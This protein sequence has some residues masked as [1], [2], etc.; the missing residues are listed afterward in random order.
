[1]SV[2][3]ITALAFA[4]TLPSAAPAAAQT[5]AQRPAAQAQ[6]APNRAAVVR[7]L[8]TAYAAVDTNKDGNLSAAELAAAEGKVQQ[9]RIAGLRTRYETE[10]TKMDTNKDGQLS[11]T[12]FMAA[13][14]SAS[15]ATPNGAALVGRLDANKD[16]RVTAAEYKAPVLANFD[17]A[18]ANK[19][20]V[21][22]Q[23][24]RAPKKQ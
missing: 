1:M 19:D 24:E 7:N 4:V 3:T 16:G 5:A 17:K 9:R 10:F 12:E 8:D 23:A 22:S 15:S 20:G 14:P 21:L 18:D 2:F 13:A 6:Q 11:K